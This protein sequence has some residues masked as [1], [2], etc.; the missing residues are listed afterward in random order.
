M[1]VNL[2]LFLSAVCLFVCS[3]IS[4]YNQ[5]DNVDVT[6][7]PVEQEVSVGSPLQHTTNKNHQL[8]VQLGGTVTLQCPQGSLG[9]WSHLDP[10]NQRLRGLGI[11]SSMPTGTYSLKDVVYQDAGYYKCVGQSPNNKKKLEVLHTLSLNV[12]G[13]NIDL[14]SAL[15]SAVRSV[16]SPEV[17]AVVQLPSICAFFVFVFSFFCLLFFR[18]VSNPFRFTCSQSIHYI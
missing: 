18:I 12:K 14:F 7:E 5:D 3:F 17:F 15:H 9:C 11:G 16:R 8:E 6:S 10:I 13:K 2:F 4:G 1:C